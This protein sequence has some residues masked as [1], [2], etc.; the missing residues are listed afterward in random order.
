MQLREDNFYL[1][2][3]K[4]NWVKYEFLYAAIVV[5][6]GCN[7]SKGMKISGA[8][9]R[10]AISEKY[11][12]KAIQKVSSDKGR[13]F[14]TWTLTNWIFKDIMEILSGIICQ[15]SRDEFPQIFIFFVLKYYKEP[16]VK[17]PWMSCLGFCRGWYEFFMIAL[18]N[19]C[20]IFW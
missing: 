11:S 17:V 16:V 20:S 6:V 2:S 13:T 5:V 12:R 7:D 9:V 3:F 15:K 14:F 19:I 8:E 10:V 18:I 4:V 1:H